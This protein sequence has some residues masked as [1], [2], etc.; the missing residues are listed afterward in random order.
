M[1]RPFHK[2]QIEI[3]GAKLIASGWFAI[4]AGTLLMLALLLI[5]LAMSVAPG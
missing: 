2:L 3:R 5:P 1:T 4:L